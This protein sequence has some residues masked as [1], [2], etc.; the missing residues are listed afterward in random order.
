MALR[1]VGRDVHR[2]PFLVGAAGAVVHEL[3]L[4]QAL[5][6]VLVGGAFAEVGAV[7]GDQLIVAVALAA[8]VRGIQEVLQD[9]EGLAVLVAEHQHAGVVAGGGAASG[10][11]LGP[12]TADVAL[13][14]EGHRLGEVLLH[15]VQDLVL[16]HVLGVDG[17]QGAV[18]G[19]V[20]E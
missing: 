1:G 13:G 15:L 10:A 17:L 8:A 4:E 14:Q 20:R 12:L 19:V 9:G 18:L 5:D 2:G 11:S 3:D 16:G 6:V 7:V